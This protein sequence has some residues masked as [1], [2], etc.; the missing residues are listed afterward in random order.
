LQTFAIPGS[1]LLPDSLSY[2]VKWVE[3]STLP[4]QFFWNEVVAS[5]NFSQLALFETD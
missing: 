1:T 3:K 4:V 5:S 2:C